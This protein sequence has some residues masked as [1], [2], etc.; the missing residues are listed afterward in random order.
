MNG[1]PLFTP[2]QYLHPAEDGQYLTDLS[3]VTPGPYPFPAPPMLMMPTPSQTVPAA[4]FYD[5]QTAV[6]NDVNSLQRADQQMIDDLSTTQINVRTLQTDVNAVRTKLKE[7]DRKHHERLD[8]KLDKQEKGNS[9][10]LIFLQKRIDALIDA[11]MVK[12]TKRDATIAD[13]N[14]TIADL[15]AL[16]ETL[17][18]QIT[19][20]ATAIRQ[21]QPG[22]DEADEARYNRAKAISSFGSSIFYDVVAAT[23][24]RETAPVKDSA[25][26]PQT[27]DNITA[28]AATAATAALTTTTTIS[29]VTTS[30]LPS[31]SKT[32]T[33]QKWKERLFKDPTPSSNADS[34]SKKREKATSTVATRTP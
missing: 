29:T 10:Q 11:L 2:P 19:S 5:F 32:P 28:T 20:Q 6:I 23:V 33:G 17:Q 3:A 25:Q 30:P 12:E 18:S 1:R 27:L 21:L 15:K 13:L 16:V 24:A 14:K 4:Q 26:P 9:R 22:T 34:K 7:Q 31:K 8:R